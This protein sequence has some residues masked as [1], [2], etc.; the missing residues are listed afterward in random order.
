[1]WSYGDICVIGDDSSKINCQASGT[2][3]FSSRG[4][5]A[6]GTE[7]IS[8]QPSTFS[9]CVRGKCKVKRLDIFS[10]KSTLL[11]FLDAGGRKIV[12]RFLRMAFIEL[13]N[14]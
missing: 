2:N 6:D 13:L 11:P 8:D 12:P 10:K 5:N 3:W 9:R 14:F 7:C 1:M 4:V